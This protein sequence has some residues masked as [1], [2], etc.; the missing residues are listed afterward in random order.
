MAA[1]REAQRKE[2]EELKE[3]MHNIQD[4]EGRSFENLYSYMRVDGI[5]ELSDS[6][7]FAF[8]FEIYKP[9]IDKEIK[10]YKSDTKSLGSG[11]V[12]HCP[13]TYEKANVIVRE[14]AELLALDL[15]EKKILASSISLYIGYD[16]ENLNKENFN[17]EV[18]YDF[19]GRP[20][21]KPENSTLRLGCETN[22]SKIIVDSFIN[23]YEKVVNKNL[24]IR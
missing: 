12:L 16:I 24:L 6:D 13:Y 15:F 5:D 2:E 23:L 4:P 1:D 3:M 7:R 8:F 11:Q 17:G 19:Y 21:P 9:L 18:V 14:M 20:V 10:N 22:S